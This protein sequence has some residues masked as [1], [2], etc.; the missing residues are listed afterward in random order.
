[1]NE[2][3]PLSPTPPPPLPPVEKPAIAGKWVMW[4]IAAAVLPGFS[5]V[6]AENKGGADALAPLFMIAALLGQLVMSIILGIA[7]S[8]RLG[9]GGGMAVLLVFVLLIASVAVGFFSALAGCAV[10]GTN[11]N[12][13]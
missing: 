8:K 6:V 11:V 10:A 2:S 3:S 4:I 1:M 13:H 12:F 9:K 5:F 7:L